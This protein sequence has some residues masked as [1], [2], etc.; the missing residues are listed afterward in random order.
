ME[1]ER[2]ENVL[3]FFKTKNGDGKEGKHFCR[4]KKMGKGKYVVEIFFLV[5]KDSEK[6]NI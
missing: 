4:G 6:E 3:S 5:G 2:E 1:K